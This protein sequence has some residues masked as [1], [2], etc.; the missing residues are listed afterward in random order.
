[1]GAPFDISINIESLGFVMH[2]DTAV[3]ALS[4]LAHDHRLSVFRLLVQAG[5]A[6]MA[7]GAIAEKLR[8]APSSLSFHL[9]Q[10]AQANLVQQRREGRSII[11]SADYAAMNGLMAFLTENCCGG[12]ACLPAAI[13]TIEGAA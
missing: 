8:I 9:A 10:L 11:Y 5:A 2:T 1:M 7:A 6:G 12:E 13:C 4:A 3:A